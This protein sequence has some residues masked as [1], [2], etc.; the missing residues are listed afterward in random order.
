MKVVIARAVSFK[1]IPLMLVISQFMVAGCHIFKPAGSNGSTRKAS[2]LNHHLLTEIEIWRKF[3]F[4]SIG[5]LFCVFWHQN[6]NPLF[7]TVLMLTIVPDC[8]TKCDFAC[9]HFP[10]GPE[11]VCQRGYTLTPNGKCVGKSTTSL[12]R[13]NGLYVFSFAL[14]VLSVNLL[15]VIRYILVAYNICYY[16]IMLVWYMHM[17]LCW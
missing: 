9:Q 8:E 14:A 13:N 4:L 16:D 17:I 7:V 2:S 10:H 12:D 6:P 15:P 5:A 3:I 11:C 1:N